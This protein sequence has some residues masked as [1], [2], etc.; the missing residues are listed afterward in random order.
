MKHKWSLLPVVLAGSLVFLIHPLFARSHPDKRPETDTGVRVVVQFSEN[1]QTTEVIRSLKE[2]MDVRI[3]YTF[4]R[5][6][7]GGSLTV[8][9]NDLRSLLEHQSITT[10]EPNKHLRIAGRPSD[11]AG[12]KLSS[13]KNPLQ[14]NALQRIRAKGPEHSNLPRNDVFVALLD[15]GV[16]EDASFIPVEK[17]ID[18]FNQTEHR[19]GDTTASDASIN[20]HGTAVAGTIAGNV[21]K[22]A[23][24]TTSGSLQTGTAPGIRLLDV[25]IAGNKG[26]TTTDLILKGLDTVLQ[27][28][29][30]NTDLDRGTHIVNLSFASKRLNGDNNDSSHSKDLLNEG[31]KNAKKNGLLSVVPAGN[32]GAKIRNNNGIIA[33]AG[34]DSTLTVGAIN[35]RNDQKPS[36]SNFGSKVD[37]VAPAQNV[38]TIDKNGKIPRMSGT[39]LSAGYASGAAAL[40]HA[41]LLEHKDMGN[42]LTEKVLMGATVDPNAEDFSSQSELFSRENT[43]EEMD[44]PI[45]NGFPVFRWK[46]KTVSLM[47]SFPNGR[48]T[49]ASMR[50]QKQKRFVRMVEKHPKYGK[51]VDKIRNNSKSRVMKVLTAPKG[52]EVCFLLCTIKVEGKGW[53]EDIAEELVDTVKN[54][55][56]VQ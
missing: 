23:S 21:Q 5:L 55:P 9:K 49:L 29:E 51:V 2:T 38:Q 31:I 42:K 18:L 11:T 15:S 10:I 3:N 8:A 25:K 44:H 33:P 26:Q 30:E 53:E 16:S 12:K 39:S 35:H 19:S 22:S 52:E 56:P 41:S 7:K 47:L 37:L 40:F 46:A 36:F 54:T 4:N 45:L 32:N 20:S 50:D 6:F 1:T 17:S 27:W 48:E 43:S 24:G 28:K 14:N 34:F 13:S